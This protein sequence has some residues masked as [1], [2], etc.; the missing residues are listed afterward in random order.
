MVAELGEHILGGRE[1]LR[2][3]ARAAG[4]QEAAV[5]PGGTGDV[6][7]ASASCAARSSSFSTLFI[8]E[9]GSSTTKVNDFGTL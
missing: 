7:H 8:A 5:R 3:R 9:R 2:P 1:E 6:R 4:T